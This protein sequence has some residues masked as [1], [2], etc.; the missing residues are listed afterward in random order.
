MNSLRSTRLQFIGIV[1]G[2]FFLSGCNK[3]I[4]W[5]QEN[6]KQTPVY[7]ENVIK[8]AQTFVRSS[9]VYSQFATVAMF[10]AIFLTD[11]A[12]MLY[13]DYHKQ[14][15]AISLEQ[16]SLLRARMT[17]E[18]KYFIS[19]YVIGHQKE[20]LYNTSKDL[21]TGSYHKNSELLGGKDATWNVTMIVNGREYTPES[22]RVVDLPFEYREFFKG[23]FSQHSNTY[24]VRFSP[25]GADQKL[26][27]V[28][29]KK[30]T[31]M[32]RFTSPLYKTELVW[33]NLVYGL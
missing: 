3:I 11:Q 8:A 7:C 29:H 13:V 1:F 17:N 10:D 20:H 5:G 21:F 28:P 16:E 12:R 27:L 19:F 32:L 18:N 6:F 30:H 22:V 14:T 4:N 33:K 15:T 2:I 25:V 24:L 31:V 23:R 9:I 26:I